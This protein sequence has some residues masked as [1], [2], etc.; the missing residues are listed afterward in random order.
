[1][2]NRRFRRR[3]GGVLPAVLILLVLHVSM[4]PNAAGGP[5]RSI[6]YSLADWNPD[7]QEPLPRIPLLGS[8]DPEAREGRSGEA[9]RANKI[10]GSSLLISGLLMCS[11]GIASWEVEKYQCCP[12]NNTGNVVKIVAGVI[13]FNAGL[14][15]LLTD[16]D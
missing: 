6:A 13:L 14:I 11:W 10:V 4:P 9:E 8:D 1:M 15:Y 16:G 5:P 12:A 2:V 3:S 7:K